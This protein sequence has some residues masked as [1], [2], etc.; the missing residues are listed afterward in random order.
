[1]GR[2]NSPGV[3]LPLLSVDS[4]MLRI[5]ALSISNSCCG[6]L[7]GRGV[8]ATLFYQSARVLSLSN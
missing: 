3:L 7:M 1:L 5:A 2:S 8:T 4:M 6:L